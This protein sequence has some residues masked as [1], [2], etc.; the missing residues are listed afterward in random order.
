MGYDLTDTDTNAHRVTIGTSGAGKTYNTA[1]ELA[2]LLSLG[3]VGILLDPLE[4]YRAFCA[5]WDGI[6]VRLNFE[7]P[8][9]TNPFY[10]PL[11]ITH[12]S[13]VAANLNE[14]AGNATDRLNW[15]GYGVLSDALGYFSEAWT[16]GEAQISHF[17]E[18]VLIPGTFTADVERQALGRDIANRLM[19]Y[20]GR[21]IYAKFFDGP[22]TFEFG[23]RLTVIE[24]KELEKAQ[25]LKAVL[26]LG[27]M[28]LLR[29]KT[30]SPAWR[31]RQ[32]HI[33]ADE[34]WAFLD[35]EETA[36]VFKTMILTGRN[37]GL[38]I[39]F[40]T[41]L[42]SHLESP[43]GKVIRGIVDKVLFLQQDAS[44]FPAI[45]SAFNLTKDEQALF[46]R[47]KKHPTWNSGYLRMNSRPGGI[48]RI[49][50]DPV[51]HLLMTQESAIRA[52]RE[53]L[54][55]AHP[56]EEHAAIVAWLRQK[57]VLRDA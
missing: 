42:A 46:K 31:G 43:V 16:G 24:F 10:G 6:Y 45:A 19:I 4:N 57:E 12:R 2:E 26:F 39:D 33:K 37:D 28:N 35:Y 32:K 9:C 14:M 15:T 51:L 7:H 5:F 20:Y 49:F 48:I 52:E 44:E 53:S 30:K 54:L 3:H 11:D 50:G 41:Q 47:V 38:S 34:L 27:L 55:D 8:P 21:G 22:N 17:V 1:K 56:G 36:Q 25:K 40:M 13:F 18:T 29:L 23:D